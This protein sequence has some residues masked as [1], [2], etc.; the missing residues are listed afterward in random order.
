MSNDIKE[1]NKRAYSSL[2]RNDLDASI[3]EFEIVLQREERNVDALYGLG[4]VL[5]QKS[6]YQ[7]SFQLLSL[8]AEIDPKAPDIALNLGYVLAKT[9]NRN[10]ALKEFQRATKYCGTDA[11]LCSALADA[12][13]G[14]FEAHG[15]LQILDRMKALT[16]KDQILMSRAYGLKGQWSESVR[17][18]HR[19][20]VDVSGDVSVLTELAKAAANAGDFRVAI[21]TFERILKSRTP[22]SYDYIRFA[23]LLLLAKEDERANIAINIAYDSGD[24]SADL[25][26]IKAKLARLNGEYEVAK[27]CIDQVIEAAPLNGEA[28]MMRAELVSDTDSAAV[29]VSLNELLSDTPDLGKQNFHETSLLYFSAAIF[30]ERS[31][32]YELAVKHLRQANNTRMDEQQRTHAV[33]DGQFATHRA[34][35]IK[36]SFN[37]DT[38]QKPAAE[39]DGSLRLQPIFIVGMPRSGT[40][41]IEKIIGRHA[42][43]QNLGEQQAMIMIASDFDLYR[44]SGQLAEPSLLTSEHWQHMRQA[45]LDKV[46]DLNKPVFTDKM[47]YNFENVGLILK[48]F[49][50]AKVIQVHRDKRDVALSIYQ[51]P[52]PLNHKYASWLADTLHAVSLSNELMDHWSELGLSQIHNVN[53][54]DMVTSPEVYAKKLVEFCGLSWS[55]ELLE[56]SD[57][58]AKSF[59]FSELQAREKISNKRIGRWKRYAP[60]FPEFDDEFN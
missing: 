60:H 24:R 25:H 35:S 26:L 58:A 22:S 53:Y 56:P 12:F 11:E 59:T 40:T 29:E 19:L 31:E 28:W 5:L 32:N 48:L 34:A 10:R 6:D 8:A 50:E 41:L 2:Q 47:P 55:P 17:I 37:Q 54:E 30:A 20:A 33:Y 23:D 21:D 9:G 39:P 3:Q 42:D 51:L 18:L 57:N 49:P 14:L 36:H 44:D 13:L 1:L 7:K 46:S 16:P 15:A 27:G 38:M 52:F 4:T 45:Y 43:V